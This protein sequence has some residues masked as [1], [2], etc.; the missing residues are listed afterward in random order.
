MMDR[1]FVWLGRQQI[2][3]AITGLRCSNAANNELVGRC[4]WIGEDKRS[5][6]LAV[7]VPVDRQTR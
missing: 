1:P 7:G 5:S 6:H 3:V 4:L 2:G